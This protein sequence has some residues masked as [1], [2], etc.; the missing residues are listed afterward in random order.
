MDLYCA[1][2]YDVNKFLARK[3]ERGM[4]NTC[5][6]KHVKSIKTYKVRNTEIQIENFNTSI[7]SI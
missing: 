3:T 1:Y 5:N 2:L 4:L 7:E 6:L